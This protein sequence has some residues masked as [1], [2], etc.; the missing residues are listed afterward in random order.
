MSPL[1][2][3]LPFSQTPLGETRDDD[4]VKRFLCTGDGDTQGSAI[5]LQFHCVADCARALLL[6][7][8]WT[9]SLRGMGGLEPSPPSLITLQTPMTSSNSQTHLLRPSGVQSRDPRLPAQRPDAMKGR[10]NKTNTNKQTHTSYRNMEPRFENRFRMP[11]TT[12]QDLQQREEVREKEGGQRRRK[13]G[14]RKKGRVKAK[15]GKEG[16]EEDMKGG[17]GEMAQ[18]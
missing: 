12:T 7:C 17:A 16:E 8:N 15:R 18:G 9:G 4:G 13:K 10:G 3:D 11:P 6:I 1:S 14:R 5:A 2:S